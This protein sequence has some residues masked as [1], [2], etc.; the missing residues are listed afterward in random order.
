M[1]TSGNA[2]DHTTAPLPLS[3]A[4]TWVIPVQ[5][6]SKNSNDGSA[7]PEPAGAAANKFVSVTDSFVHS[8]TVSPVEASSSVVWLAL[9]QNKPQSGGT[10]TV[11]SGSD[12]VENAVPN[13]QL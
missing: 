5:F 8:H 7:A 4:N 2:T 6:A 13:S 3:S 9:G 10:I 11:G 1:S 12:R